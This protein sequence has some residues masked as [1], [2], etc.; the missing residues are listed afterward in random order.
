MDRA[1]LLTQGQNRDGQ[2]CVSI[3]P[4]PLKR[5]LRESTYSFYSI[6][7]VKS[8]SA[9]ARHCYRSTQRVMTCCCSEKLRKHCP[10]E[11][12]KH[13]VVGQKQIG[14]GTALLS[15]RSKRDSLR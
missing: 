5:P 6:T 11:Q 4:L 7:S 8:K 9:V 10:W 13:Q 12:E 1:G 15:R 2:R 3:I 14:G